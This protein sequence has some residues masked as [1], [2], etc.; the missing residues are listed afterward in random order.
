MYKDKDKQ[1]QAVREA[2]RQFR[3]KNNDSTLSAQKQGLENAR[4]CSVSP[5]LGN[6]HPV[7]P[8]ECNTQEV[9]P[10]NTP[11]VTKQ[12]AAQ[13]QSYNPMMVGYVPPKG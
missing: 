9:I 13:T 5:D 7:I 2:V 10:C 8:S 1:R 3:A 12:P 6:T 4:G 11:T